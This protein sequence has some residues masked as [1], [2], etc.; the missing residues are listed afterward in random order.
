MLVRP[1]C[2]AWQ[3]VRRSRGSSLLQQ[4]LRNIPQHKLLDLP[5]P[6]QGYF[7]AAILS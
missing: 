7:I 4:F 1:E 3:Q 6:R 5:T 2:D